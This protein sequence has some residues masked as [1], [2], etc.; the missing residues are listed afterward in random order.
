MLANHKPVRAVTIQRRTINSGPIP[1]GVLWL[2]TLV[3][4]NT[5]SGSVLSKPPVVSTVGPHTSVALYIRELDH[6]DKEYYWSPSSPDGKWELYIQR[7]SPDSRLA[8]F[9]SLRLRGNNSTESRIL[10]TLWDADVGSG[11]RANVRWSKDGKAL[12]IDGDTRGFSY[13]PTPDPMKF[14]PF[15][16]VY[17]VEEDKLYAVPSKGGANQQA[18]EKGN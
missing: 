15:N 12:Q 17:M 8:C 11:V 16:F 1:I 13:E 10:F 4:C 3:S 5:F 9:Y 2:L 7:E 18:S 14:D 6:S